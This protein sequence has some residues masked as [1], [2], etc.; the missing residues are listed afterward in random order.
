M[1]KEVTPMSAKQ[2][3]KLDMRSAETRVAKPQAS[4]PQPETTVETITPERAA[5]WV[6]EDRKRKETNPR[7]NRP[8]NEATVSAYAR[9]MQAGKWVFS[10]A[11]ICFDAEG[12]LI[13]GQHRLNACCLAG[14]PFR[15]LVIRNMPHGAQEVMDQGRIRK[16][17]DILHLRGNTHNNRLAAALRAMT[18]IKHA[19]SAFRGYRATNAELLQILERHPR[20]VESVGMFDMPPKGVAPGLLAAIHYVGK[21]MLKEPE[22]ADAFAQVFVTGVPTYTGDPA[23][24]LR[25]STLRHYAHKRSR[26]PTLQFYS[27]LRAWN[28]FRKGETRAKWATPREVVTIDGLDPEQI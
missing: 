19:T 7:L 20:L 6:A 27:T 18:Y 26:L 28:A 15:C 4:D 3:M 16:L 23:H 5:K 10:E 22:K 8:L 9:D 12:N 13:N 25:E 2:A 11:A 24:A 1:E 21:H 14:V 17:P